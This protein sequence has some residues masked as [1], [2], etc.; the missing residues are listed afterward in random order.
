[1]PNGDKLSTAADVYVRSSN[2]GNFH[3]ERHLLEE[4]DVVVQPSID[5]SIHW[6]DFVL[7]RHLIRFGEQA[8]RDKCSYI[9]QTVAHR[10][11]FYTLYK[12]SSRYCKRLVQGKDRVS[13]RAL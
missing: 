3:F 7:A 10:G 13:A 11:S 1:M 8:V 5:N 6:T 12:Q 2:I 9:Q 4:A